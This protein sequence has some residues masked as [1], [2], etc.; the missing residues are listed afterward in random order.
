M[1]DLVTRLALAAADPASEPPGAVDNLKAIFTKP[2]NIPIMLMI[3]MVAFFTY[4]GLRD[5]I[6]HDRLIKQGRKDEI[7]RAMQD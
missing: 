1:L 3:V 6:K 7:L 4:M 2:D 5:G